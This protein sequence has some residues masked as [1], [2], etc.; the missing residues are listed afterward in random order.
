MRRTTTGDS[1]NRRS[2]A[3]LD[4]RRTWESGNALVE[5]EH[6]AITA[7]MARTEQLR[8]GG[9]GSFR[10]IQSRWY[11]EMIRCLN[12]DHR[13]YHHAE[14]L[15]KRPQLSRIEWKQVPDRWQRP[16]LLCTLAHNITISASSY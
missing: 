6:D 1:L 3:Q 9:C 15:D 14:P 2:T 8:Q 16:M 7:G 4:V 12:S 11:P 13:R 10:W 5:G